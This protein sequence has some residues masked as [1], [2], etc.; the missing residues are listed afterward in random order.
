MT[1]IFL[2]CLAIFA[3][4]PLVAQTD[5]LAAFNKHIVEKWSE[6]Y[7]RIGQYRVKGSVYLLGEPFQGSISYANGTDLPNTKILY[8]VYNQKVGPEIEGKL[9]DA[10][11][12]VKAFTI[13]MTPQQGGEKLLFQNAAQFGAKQKSYFNVIFNGPRYSLLKQFRS[14]LIADPTNAFTKD[15]RL[16]EQYVEYYLFDSND[17]HLTKIKLREKDVLGF[18][19][20]KNLDTYVKNQG[21]DLS[22]E[23]DIVALLRYVHSNS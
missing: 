16:L 8:D 15:F 19:G 11:Q 6:E 4:H 22:K 3:V 13:L 5:N 10:D 12:E 23:K 9:L 21:L 7:I 14:R 20:H 1:K 17:Q 2:F 18:L